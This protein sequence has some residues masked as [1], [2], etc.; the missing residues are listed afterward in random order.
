[1]EIIGWIATGLILIGYYLNANK[2]NTSWIAWFVGNILMATYSVGIEAWPQL[3]LAIVLIVLNIY[4]YLNWKR[5][6][7]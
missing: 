5:L 2:K 7:K 4:G 6:G 1:M 3:V